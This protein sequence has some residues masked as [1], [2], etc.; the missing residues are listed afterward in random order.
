MPYTITYLQA[1]NI[2]EKVYS[3]K[4]SPEHLVEIVDETHKMMK[5]TGAKKVIADCSD[6][7]EGYTAFDLYYL[8]EKISHLQIDPYSSEAII[9]STNPDTSKNLLF[10]ETLATNNGYKCKTFENRAAAMEWLLSH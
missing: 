6:L 8:M 7:T 2:I 4:L 9:L 1:Y 10:F 5:E 3:G